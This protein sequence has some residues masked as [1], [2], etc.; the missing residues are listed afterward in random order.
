MAEHE[1]IELNIGQPLDIRHSLESGQVFRWQR[2]E[3]W[4]YGGIGETLIALCQFG[5]VL[6]IVHDSGET[7]NVIDLVSKFLRLDDNIEEIYS[8][9]GTDERIKEAISAYRGLR[10]L[11]Q[12]PWECLIG[13]ICSANSNIPRISSS[14]RSIAYNYGAKRTLGLFEGYVFPSAEDIASL[15][16]TPLRELKIGFR[17]RYIARVAEIIAAGKLDLYGLKY[18]PYEDAKEELKSLPGIGDKVADCVLLFSLD[19][20]EACPI[21]RWI[22]RAF[23]DW[24]LLDSRFKYEEF[25]KW[26]FDKWGGFAGYAQQYLFQSRRLAP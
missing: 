3:D 24:Y 22:R 20:L 14:M 11:R 2:Q 6:K 7:E 21:D 15:G 25:Y 9:I 13:F 4:H 23:E 8:V 12:D 16:E 18:M 5:S 10:I 26:A 1:I 19:K 17:A